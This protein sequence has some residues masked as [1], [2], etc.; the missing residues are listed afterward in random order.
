MNANFVRYY[1]LK[2]WYTTTLEIHEYLIV[3]EFELEYVTC[4]EKSA[5]SLCI[6]KR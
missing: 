5:K 6:S 1:K 2:E 3:F 4:V